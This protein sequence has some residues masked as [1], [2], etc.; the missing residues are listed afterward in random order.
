MAES[1]AV[2]P[3]NL[4]QERYQGSGTDTEYRVRRLQGADHVP[5][6]EAVL[7]VPEGLQTRGTGTSKKAARSQAA[8]AMLAQLGRSAAQHPSPQ[9]KKVP[10]SQGPSGPAGLALDLGLLLAANPRHSDILMKCPGGAIPCHRVILAARSPFFDRLLATTNNKPG[11]KLEIKEFSVET[12]EA[13]VEFMYT[14]EVRREVGD[15]AEV[16]RAAVTFQ[17]PGLANIGC[18]RIRAG[19]SRGLDL[20]R[21]RAMEGAREE[22]G[23][24]P[25]LQDRLATAQKLLQ[26][27][28]VAEE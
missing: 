23:A 26:E 24:D 2:R 18:Q 20:L 28:T 11:N 4:L 21:N 15:P 27:L 13:A 22:V 9:G 19:V 14:G 5:T 6:F 16:V 10:G 12:V 8:A 3:V 1:A 25:L 17:L 7:E